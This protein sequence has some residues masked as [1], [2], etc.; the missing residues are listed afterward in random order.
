MLQV[1]IS[2]K[3][4]TILQYKRAEIIQYSDWLWAIWWVLFPHGQGILF[5]T[6]S[7]L[8]LGI[9]QPSIHVTG[10][11][12]LEHEVEQST[13]DFDKRS[14]M[15]G[16]LPSWLTCTFIMGCLSTRASFM[17]IRMPVTCNKPK[18]EP[19]R[20]SGKLTNGCG[21]LRVHD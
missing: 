18:L 15:T 10:G 11:P 20:E 7:I 13:Y 17:T 4:V 12:S 8:V 3:C 21:L 14:K 1:W 2:T 9:T 5:T 6:R 19:I 16:A